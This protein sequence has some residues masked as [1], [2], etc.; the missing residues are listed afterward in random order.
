MREANRPVRA[1]DHARGKGAV[2]HGL[3]D[4]EA[5]EELGG[6]TADGRCEQQRRSRCRRQLV[7]ACANQS[8]QRLRNAERLRGVDVRAQ[9]PGELERVERVSTGRLVHTQEGRAWQL[10]LEACLE[11]LV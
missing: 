5:C 3:G 1:L 10:E 8:L 9:S 4:I 6:R 11:K 2:E 7:E